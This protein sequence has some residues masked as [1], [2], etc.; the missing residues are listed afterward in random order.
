MSKYL[1]SPKK[2]YKAG[3]RFLVVA[4]IG[5]VIIYVVVFATSPA[6]TFDA[7]WKVVELNDTDCIIWP[8]PIFLSV[9]LK[10]KPTFEDGE[11]RIYLYKGDDFDVVIEKSEP[12]E[13]EPNE[14]ECITEGYTFHIWEPNDINVVSLDFI[15]T[16]PD[17]IE[18]EKDL[19]FE[20]F[21]RYEF[22]GTRWDKVFTWPKGTKIYF[23]DN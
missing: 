23:K 16:W 22:D 15:P 19:V 9:E 12:N 3:I 6:E 2:V 4:I 1:M 21:I 20:S 14:P 8:D 11:T 18:L 17:Y 5:V 10:D 13:P 7:G